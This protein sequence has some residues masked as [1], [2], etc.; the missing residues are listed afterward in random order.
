MYLSQNRNWTVWDGEWLRLILGTCDCDPFSSVYIWQT[1]IR[2]LAKATMQHWTNLWQVPFLHS[3]CSAWIMLKLWA[4]SSNLS[5]L[6]AMLAHCLSPFSWFADSWARIK[7]YY[8]PRICSFAWKITSHLPPL[9]PNVI[10]TGCLQLCLSRNIRRSRPLWD[11]PSFL[12]WSWE[13]PKT[14]GWNQKP[15]LAHFGPICPE[16]NKTWT[17]NHVL[18]I[19]LTCT[20]ILNKDWRN[21][22]LL[23]KSSLTVLKSN[24][25]L[26]KWRSSSHSLYFAWQLFMLQGK[27]MF[28]AP[29]V[30]FFQINHKHWNHLYIYII[31]D[32][33]T[34]WKDKDWPLEPCFKRL[35]WW[36]LEKYEL[37]IFGVVK[38]LWKQQVLVDIALLLARLRSGPQIQWTKGVMKDAAFDTHLC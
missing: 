29:K 10:W 7:T 11:K 24:F 25:P 28:L 2:A 35:C 30:V 21:L 1:Q 16:M 36:C 33:P 32:L 18:N 23:V 31:L 9:F 37:L 19:K 5:K 38:C 20:W 4:F 8:Q 15:C 22:F 12:A 17:Q 3:M 27:R 26:E 13:A 14:S 34:S 6:F